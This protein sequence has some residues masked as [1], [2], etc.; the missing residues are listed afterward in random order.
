M[1]SNTTRRIDDQ[2]WL[3][4]VLLAARTMEHHIGNQLSLTI[5]YSELLANDPSL[6]S[7]ARERAREAL[8]GS[9][10]AV[11]TLRQ[12][13]R[14]TRLVVEDGPSGPIIDLERSA[15]GTLEHQGF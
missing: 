2:T 8:S 7:Y 9:T 5:G 12:L 13:G 6:P 1:A 10:A 11:L 14:L 4:G 15:D 3:E